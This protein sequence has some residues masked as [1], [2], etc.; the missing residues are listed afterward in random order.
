MVGDGGVWERLYGDNTG[1]ISLLQNILS[2]AKLNDDIVTTISSITQSIVNI[3]W[4]C[5]VQILI[6]ISG[7]KAIPHSV[8]EAAA[9]EGATSW[10]FF[11]KIT[12]PILKPI[13]LLNIIYTFVDS[14]TDYSNPIVQKIF[15]LNQQMSYSYSAA[16][17]WVYFGVIAV[18]L[19]VLYLILKQ[20]TVK[21]E[22]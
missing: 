5:G 18:L 13:T 16:V 6:F 4:K 7:L 21:N 11:W 14:F 10:E 20:S 12:F 19:L 8:K 3:V 1:Q 15:K 22:R 17:S 2:S 9:I